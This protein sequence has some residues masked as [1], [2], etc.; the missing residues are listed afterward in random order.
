MEG[1]VC[2]LVTFLIII[3]SSIQHVSSMLQEYKFVNLNTTKITVPKG[4]IF[5][6][7]VNLWRKDLLWR[8]CLEMAQHTFCYS[9]FT[10]LSQGKNTNNKKTLMT[11]YKDH[12][13]LK[14]DEISPN[15]V[16]YTH[17]IDLLSPKTNH[18]INKTLSLGTCLLAP[19]K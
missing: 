2:L 10:K 17:K 19:N 15:L 7:R 8:T 13:F 5:F 4:L 12:L 1:L 9:I 16:Y 6:P 11:T 3:H 18:S 14:D